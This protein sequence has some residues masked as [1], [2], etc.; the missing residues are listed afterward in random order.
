MSE[1]QET[2]IGNIPGDWYY[3]PLGHFL[4]FGHMVLQ[5]QCRQWK[6]ALT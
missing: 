2:E 3:E 1:W 6:Q 4:S 5:T